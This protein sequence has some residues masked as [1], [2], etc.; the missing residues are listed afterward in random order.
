MMPANAY[1]EQVRLVVQV[2]PVVAQETCFALKGGTAL[3][4]FLHNMPR[5]SVDIDLV[6]VPLDAR[7]EALKASRVALESICARIN[8]GAVLN[9]KARVQGNRPDALRVLVQRGTTAIKIELSPVLRGTVHPPE[10]K[11][12][13]EIAADQFGDVRML[14]VSDA[15]LYGG[16]ICAAL[17]RQHPRDLFDIKLLLDENGLTREVFE[18]FLVYLISHNRPIRELL[19]PRL[20]DIRQTY[21][22]QF[23]GMSR[24]PFSLE[25]LEQARLD[26][27]ARLRQLMTNADAKFLISVKRG[28]PDWSHFGYEHIQQLPGVRWK[29]RNIQGMT[30]QARL[31]GQQALKQVLTEHYNFEELHP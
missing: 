20:V 29:L 8:A 31:S 7:D 27:L 28:D 5:L 23:Q 2:L 15:D 12:I 13:V 26:L 6:Y 19:A 24:E 17:D 1:E 21:I 30:S 3:N 16:K 22:D 10:M 9:A 18:G 11:Q 14:V 25:A 4:L